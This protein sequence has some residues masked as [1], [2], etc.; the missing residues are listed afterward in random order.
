M[1]GN[2]LQVAIRNMGRSMRFTALHLAGLALG[3]ASVMLIAWYV[4]DELSYDELDQA[5]RVFRVN[6]YWGNDPKTDVFAS[7]PPPLASTIKQE[8]P[9]VEKVARAFNWNHS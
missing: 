5:D 1:I 9:E 2:Y 4:Y 6:S 7:A 8:I 3:L